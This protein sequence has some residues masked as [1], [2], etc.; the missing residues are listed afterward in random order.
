MPDISDITLYNWDYIGVS[1]ITHTA[2]CQVAFLG[3]YLSN[4]TVVGDWKFLTTCVRKISLVNIKIGF[5]PFA[6]F[7]DIRNLEHVPGR[8]INLAMSVRGLTALDLI[9]LGGHVAEEYGIPMRGREGA[10][11]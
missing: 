4:P 11:Q 3:T 7:A 6:A 10:I 5:H 8:S 9:G 2:T 1:I